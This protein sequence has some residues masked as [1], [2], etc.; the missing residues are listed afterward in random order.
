[1]ILSIVVHKPHAFVTF[2]IPRNFNRR[3]SWPSRTN[4]PDPLNDD[5]G[6]FAYVQEQDQ[7]LESEF[8]P[9]KSE[10]TASGPSKRRG[11]PCKHFTALVVVYVADCPLL[12]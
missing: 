7:G 1:V 2:L 12:S 10:P 6:L 9:T 11:L 4:P 8:E 5:L 3:A